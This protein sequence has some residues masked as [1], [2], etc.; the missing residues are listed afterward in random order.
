MESHELD[1]V[2]DSIVFRNEENGYTVC[3][4]KLDG[5]RDTVTLVGVSS[6]MWVGE[7]IRAEGG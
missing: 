7:N 6:A 4:V 1:G 5:Q 2:V 3:R